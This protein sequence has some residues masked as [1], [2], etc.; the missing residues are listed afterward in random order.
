MKHKEEQAKL[1]SHQLFKDD[2]D[3]G[4]SVALQT[5]D[6]I[7]T[8]EAQLIEPSTH[9]KHLHLTS[10]RAS[11]ES[12]SQLAAGSV[13]TLKSSSK[14]VVKKEKGDAPEGK[15]KTAAD[16]DSGMSLELQHAYAASVKLLAILTQTI[17]TTLPALLE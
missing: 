4:M 10:S 17:D 5:A 1:A 16:K 13:A 2:I 12:A 6:L 7:P 15:K 8:R 11:L 9:R 3:D 14:V